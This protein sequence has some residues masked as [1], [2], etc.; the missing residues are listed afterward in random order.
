M[1]AHGRDDKGTKLDDPAVTMVGFEPLADLSP[2]TERDADTATVWRPRSR[3]LSGVI[4]GTIV[5]LDPP[6][7]LQP[8]GRW[9]VYEELGIV[10][11]K[12]HG[13]TARV[14]AGTYKLIGFGILAGI[15]TVLAGY[16]G[17]IGFYAVS[18][19]WI[20]PVVVSPFD[21]K[22]VALQ[23]QLASHRNQRDKIIADIHDADRLI[24]RE[25]VFAHEFARSVAVER[26]NRWL[27]VGTLRT[28]GSN[29]LATR[30]HIRL[31]NE[32]FAR[33]S[34]DKLRLDY[35][36]HL[37]DQSAMLA[38]NFQ[39]A[40]ISSAMLSLSE[41]Q[42]DLDRKAGELARQ[43]RSLN[44]VLA[45]DG[46][47][48]SYDVL[49]IK[50]DLDS[51]ILQRARAV[52]AKA[53]LTASLAREDEL[54]AALESSGYLRAIHDGAVVAL[55]P[56]G[57]LANAKPGSRLYACK[58]AMVWCRQIGSIV[59]VIPGEVSFKH[60]KR[61][62]QMRGQLVELLLDDARAGHDEVLFAGTPPLG[63]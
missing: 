63:V 1:R 12:V 44:S 5:V 56:Y 14:V 3:P 16:V 45:Q 18:S 59:E 35:D 47:A 40:Q 48:L 20:A 28:L 6:V 60:P 58:L 21:P 51:S 15:L 30:N 19:S 39:L 43:G 17:T 38:G 23:T 36:A 25:T 10:A 34:S 61:S 57:N 54:I 22:V 32:G 33:T 31:A 27:A 49:T 11:P 46:R 9:A 55:V 50:R 53:T 29:A 13:F 37:V 62:T 24:A 42:A 7:Q 4:S 26:S 2:S 41:Q 52:G 8:P